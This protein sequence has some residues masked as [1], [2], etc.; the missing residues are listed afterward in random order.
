MAKFK[1]DSALGEGARDLGTEERTMGRTKLALAAVAAALAVCVTSVGPAL[2]Q[3]PNQNPTVTAARTPTGNVRV[4][5]PIAF[6]ATASDPDGDSLTY[7]WD[8]GDGTTST[9]QNPSKT[10]LAAATRT[11]R[12]TVDDGHGGTA[13]SQLTIVVQANRAPSAA[14]LV[15]TPGAG[16]APL[17]VTWTGA[18]TDP[19]GPSHVVSYSWDL[20]GDG[21]DDSTAQ[22]PTFTYATPGTYSPRVRV[23]DQ[24]GGTATRTF[25]LSVLSTERDPNARF[26]ILIFSKTAGFRHSSIDEGIAAVRLL[27]QQNNFQVDAIEESSLF[28]D[29]V[30]ALYDGVLWLSTTGDTLNDTQ[31]A[32]FERY[33]QHGGGYIGI[34]SAADGEYLWPWYGR[35]VGG[36]FRNHPNGTPTA[37]VV[38]ED[39]THPSTAHLLDRWTR[40]DEWYNYQGIVNPVV[41]GGGVDYSPR[42]SGVHVLLTMDESTYAEADGSDGVDDDHPIA[43][44]NRYDGGRMWYTGMGH[45]EASFVNADFLKHVLGGIETAV[46][47]IP[48]AACGNRAPT[49]TASASPASG[50]APLTTTLTVDA[51]DPD[52]DDLTYAW[53]FNGDGTT[54]S[55]LQSPT[56]TFADPGTY[57]ASVIVTDEHGVATLAT[58]SVEAFENQAPVTLSALSPAAPN[59]Q[60]GWYVGPVTVTLSATDNAG[61][62]GVD[63]TEYRIDGGAWTTYSGPFAVGSDGPHTVGYRSTDLVGNVEVEK[64]VSFKVDNAILGTRQLG[65]ATDTLSARQPEAFRNV[66]TISG[67]VGQLTVFLTNATTAKWLVAGIYADAGGHP[68]QLLGQSPVTALTKNAWNTVSLPAVQIAAGQPYWIAVQGTGGVLKIRTFSGGR[69]TQDSETGPTRTADVAACHVADRQGL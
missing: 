52:G 46:A 47:E 20:D 56:R 66:A 38:R 57:T 59:G 28:T 25:T 1:W 60:D 63:K 8:F 17:Q 41:N 2:A 44:C 33:I 21:T 14:G 26:R 40:V 49:A 12:V 54:D 43:W 39:A 7:L 58:T 42:N 13:G 29:D 36:Y 22:N 67:S 10:Y 18:A 24:F 32:A 6:T 64:T 16:F 30:L 35:F 4:G 50:I 3:A 34:H 69:G 31:Q 62:S 68:G 37:T 51:T 53:D 61:G 9:E 27:G 11:A 23:S 55:T 45:T 15:I 19:D 5:V 48:D 65:P